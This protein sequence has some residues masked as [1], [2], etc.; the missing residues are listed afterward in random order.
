MCQIKKNTTIVSIRN[1]HGS[2]FD[3]RHFEN[4]CNENKIEYNF[5][6]TRTPQ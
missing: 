5:S 4:F 1:D 2:E 3:N 6:A